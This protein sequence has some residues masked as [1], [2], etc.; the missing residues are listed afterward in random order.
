MIENNRNYHREK[1]NQKNATT[2]R[3]RQSSLATSTKRTQKNDEIT[4]SFDYVIGPDGTILAEVLWK[5]RRLEGKPYAFVDESSIRELASSLPPSQQRHL[6]KRSSE[7]SLKKIESL[8][9]NS[10]LE[11][12]QT[13]S[14]PAEPSTLK[15]PIPVQSSSSTVFPPPRQQQQQHK[16]EKNDQNIHDNGQSLNKHQH[17]VQ[18]ENQSPISFYPETD[19]Q[20][21]SVGGAK[22]QLSNSTHNFP[23]PT[24]NSK[25]V[26]PLQ[27]DEFDDDDLF[28][29]FDVDQ[30]ISE[31]KNTT[32]HAPV[33]S[34]VTN[35][36][37]RPQ[38]FSSSYQ[39]PETEVRKSQY[40]NNL[41][42]SKRGMENTFNANSSGNDSFMNNNSNNNPSSYHQQHDPYRSESAGYSSFDN[43]NFSDN[44]EQGSSS[45][46]VSSTGNEYKQHDTQHNSSYGGD[47]ED[48]PPCPGHNLPCRLFTASTSTNLGRQF[49]KCSLPEGE[50]CD[51]FQWKD[52]MEGNWNNNDTTMG[53]SSNLDS[54][55]ILD[56]NEENRR[57]FGHRSFRRGQKDVIEKAIQGRD[58]FVLMPTGYVH[59]LVFI[60]A[61]LS[62][63]MFI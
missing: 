53:S 58:V 62:S 31:H 8:I 11:H 37:N 47:N 55:Q 29:D 17:Q 23:K 1:T 19:F 46:N 2:L 48:A 43:N 26:H 18:Q 4:S 42:S 54:G 45:Y 5:K 12:K 24:H 35:H 28:A 13:A 34:D 61:F 3:Q 50:S 25:I 21:A 9:K 6:Y 32:N 30:A 57:V 41:N 36:K 39:A 10:I 52:G 20:D 22:R 40:G 56:M 33:R 15:R 14:L 60:L 51:F 27:D 7:I 16:E 44:R 38:A 59:C 63:M 49:Y